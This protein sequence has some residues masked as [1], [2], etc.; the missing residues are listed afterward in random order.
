MQK[1]DAVCGVSWISCAT[2]LLEGDREHSTATKECD[3]YFVPRHRK[4][5]LPCPG[6]SQHLP[7]GCRHLTHVLHSAWA[8]PATSHSASLLSAER[9][10]GT[11]NPLRKDCI[12]TLGTTAGVG[13]GARTTGLNCE[14]EVVLCFGQHLKKLL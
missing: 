11:G 3:E 8:S 5:T 9:D 6:R 1:E 14:T 4:L 7:F 2:A 10:K 12:E 13:Q